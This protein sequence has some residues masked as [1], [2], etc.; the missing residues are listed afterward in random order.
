MDWM[1]TIRQRPITKDTIEMVFDKLA[2][3][4]ATS[5]FLLLFILICNVF[6]LAFSACIFEDLNFGRWW[7]A[8]AIFSLFSF[9]VV[10]IGYF[11]RLHD[12]I[13]DLFK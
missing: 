1:S 13:M 12:F 9:V 5:F 2:M 7:S 8:V 3:I 11:I 4:L 10:L 6:W